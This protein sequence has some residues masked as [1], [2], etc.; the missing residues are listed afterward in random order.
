M[1]IR[2][3]GVIPSSS[4]EL[5][6]ALLPVEENIPNSSTTT[7]N[8]PEQTPA[9][10]TPAESE[11][12]S[13]YAGYRRSLHSSDSDSTSHP[14]EHDDQ[15]HPD[16]NITNAYNDS[17]LHNLEPHDHGDG[18]GELFDVDVTIPKIEFFSAEN[19]DTI[20]H[21]RHEMHGEECIVDIGTQLI[22][23][24]PGVNKMTCRITLMCEGLEASIA[25]F[26]DNSIS[27]L[28]TSEHAGKAVFVHVEDTA[29][30]TGRTSIPAVF[31]P[32]AV[33]ME[34]ECTV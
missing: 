12:Y 31:F 30:P 19:R 11:S 34:G 21:D 29:A 24:V 13:N 9:M 6:N 1:Y 8:D 22:L 20:V 26:D 3:Y 14:L 7:F 18:A 2:E 23:M 25:I 27:F 4:S 10:E 5:D 33:E 28:V 16:N 32:R 17:I 15:A